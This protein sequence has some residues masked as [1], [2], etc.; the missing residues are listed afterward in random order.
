MQ[1]LQLHSHVKNVFLGLQLK[2][3]QYSPCTSCITHASFKTGMHTPLLNHSSGKA[4]Q[5]G[6]RFW[7]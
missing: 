7:P 5:S 6:F 4:T 2:Q 1:G 3:V